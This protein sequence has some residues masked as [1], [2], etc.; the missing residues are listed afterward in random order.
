MAK[1]IYVDPGHG[2][3]DPGAV[4]NGVREADVALAVGRLVAGHLRR[5]GFDVLMSRNADAPRSLKARTDEANAWGA[6]AYVSIHCNAAA[7]AQ[8]NGWEVW[9]TIHE[10]RSTGDELAEAIAAEL[11]KLPLAA[12]GTKS[13]PSTSNPQKDYY[14]V[15][16][17][18]RM[19]AV[20]VE[21]GFVTN[22]KDAAYLRSADGQAALAEAI[23]RGVVAWA[24]ERWVAP[25]DEKEPGPNAG[26]PVLRQGDRGWAVRVLQQQ[27][28]AL[29]FDPGPIDGIFGP[30]TEAAVKAF[31]RAA[32]IAVDGVVGP[33]TWS[34]LKARKST[35]S[36]P[37]PGNG[38]AMYR[39]VIGSFRDRKNAEALA[40]KARKAGFQV[41]IDPV[42]S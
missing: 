38:V 20:I 26:T 4:G 10:A 39:V 35:P 3:S 41:W 2:G 14:H 30:K 23:A 8:A 31:Q 5:C 22:A 17:E 24:G 33:V 36:A 12:R 42:R 27:L 9:H 13:K 1:R 37:P 16:R 11:R 6:D 34:H 18:T 21:C 19:P 32:G 29:G 25:A 7:S 40:E 28:K 15:I